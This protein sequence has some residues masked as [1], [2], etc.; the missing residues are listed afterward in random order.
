MASSLKFPDPFNFTA[1]NLA[2]EWR[3]W[4]KQFEWFILATR[5]GEK[6]EDVLVGVLLSLL[7][8]DGVKIYE[9]FV[10]ADAADAKK[11]KPVLDEFSDYFEPIKCEVFD[12]FRFHKRHQQQGESFD[13]WLVDLMSLVKSCNY[14]TDAVIKSVL[15]D[16]IVLGVASDVVREKLLY[17]QG[18]TFASACAIVRAC[19][20]S[21]SQLSQIAVRSDAVHALQEKAPRDRSRPH[22]SS[23]TQPAGLISCS[24]CGR[25]HKKGDCTASG[26]TCYRCGQ[27]GHYARRCSQPPTQQRRSHADGRQVAPATNQSL[28]PSHPLPA[29]R[30]TF[31]QQQLHSI[32]EVDDLVPVGASR[33]LDEE[34]VAHELRSSEVGE[35]WYEVLDIDGSAKVRFKL[36]S[37]ATCNVLPLESYK[38]IGQS[39][40][41]S[42]GPRVRNYGASG[43]YLKVLGTCVGSVVCRG[44]T[45]VVKFVVVDEPGQPPIL[46]LPTCRQMQLIK[47]IDAIT[48]ERSPE[49]PA[50][51]IEHMDVFEGIGKLPVEHDIKLASGNNYVDPVVCAAGRLPFLLEEKVYKKLEQMVADEVIVPVVE[52]T[53][54][55]SRMLVVG[56]PDGDVRLVLDPSELN[57]AILRQH[58][59]VPTVDQLFAKIGKAKYFCSLDA[60]SGF[61][62]I[63][64]TE[65]ASYLC[66][67][68]TPKGRFRFLRLPF[69]LKS[70]PEV[71]LQVMSELFGDLPGVI[72]YFD[73]FL[74]TGDT[75]ADLDFNLRNVFM[76]CREH[77][78]KLNLKKCKFF[79]QQ[80][81]WLGHV[82]GHGTLRPDPEKVDAI[83]NMPDPT[84]KVGLQRLLGMVT[85]LDKFCQGLATLTRPLRDILKKDSAWCWEAQQQKAMAELKSTLSSLPVLRLFD[86]SKP[87]LVSVDASPVG[88]GAVLMQEGQPVAFSSTTLTPTQ[89]RYCQIEKELL[90]V[91]FG[92]LRFRQYVYGQHAVVE[93]DHKPLVGLLDKPIASCSPRIQ[94]MRLQL[95][96]FD[97]SL[98]YKPGRE[99]FI[100]DT[101]SRAPSPR[102]FND[103]VTAECEEQVHHVIQ[104]AVPIMSTR[105]R[106]AEA[107]LVDPTLQSLRSVMKSGWPERK[108]QCPVAIKPYWPVR[109]DLSVVDGI[110]LC[111]T[112]LVVP[113]SL[114]REALDGVHDGHF[115]E[116]KSVLRAKSSVYWPGW[117]DQV[118]NVVASCHNCQEHRR[119][120][121]KFPLFPTR[122]PEYA[123]QF[124]SADLFEFSRVNYLLLVDAYSKWPCVVPMK[125]TTSS[126]LIGEVS[127]FFCDFGRPEEFESDNGTQFASAEFREF[128]RQIG[129]RQVSSSPEYA[130]A[131]GLAER[132]IQTVKQTLLK[133]F[134]DGKTLWESLA[135]IRSTPVSATLPAPSVLLQGRNLRGSL[136][137]LPSELAP[138]FVPAT[139]VQRELSARQASAA[140]GQARAPDA[141]MSALQ[142]GQRVRALIKDRWL[143]GAVRSV[144]SEPQSYVIQLD[145]GRLFRRT[146]WAVNMDRSSP[147]GGVTVASQKHVQPVPDSGVRV[148]Q[149]EER[150]VSTPSSRSVVHPLLPPAARLT[151]RVPVELDRPGEPDSQALPVDFHTPRPS[152]LVGGNRGVPRRLSM[153]QQTTSSDVVPG[154]AVPSGGQPVPS[155]SDRFGTTRSG[156]RFGISMTHGDRPG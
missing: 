137:F 47:R 126:A 96:R 37:G 29:Q 109:H 132:H 55:V 136:P 13:T 32:E 35:E 84:D 149:F 131:N 24:N 27:I 21:S 121:P 102:L 11:I 10:F 153:G 156:A 56:K 75:V 15:R 94:R 71:Y 12:R 64:L 117:E 77:N 16:Q 98:V 20:S 92:L 26:I 45:Y 106:Y 38:N 43:G 130:Q 139:V 41:L 66:T 148:N 115:G 89:R 60:A 152:R 76:R 135:A 72:I 127:R 6:D 120:N 36:D 23:S 101:L 105:R 8:R 59:A 69:G 14:G 138:K 50:T 46:G 145:D 144:C 18:L 85:Y 90:A 91:Q 114:R 88:L 65:R 57:K 61:Y 93:T 111:G 33:L 155:A 141:R 116:S 62:Q 151:P 103:D 17:D 80:L 53:E 95:Q 143:S 150:P 140:Y 9:T 5:K 31:M 146:R 83:V 3:Q 79:L 39:V 44:S 48:S 58:F 2:L 63:P 108:S 87:V 142:I 123:F 7:G 25:R 19:E 67:M 74:V 110:I 125:S 113:H 68:A 119:K 30:G 1:S 100:A 40:P 54:W 4:R 81:P 112:R 118:R 133:M 42:P 129:V 86:V 82:I 97:F 52:P 104:S 122:I 147:F 134:E 128:C 73:D 51:V 70:A 99:L 124:V 154:P 22:S 78:L 34:Y 107:T 49:L 28:K